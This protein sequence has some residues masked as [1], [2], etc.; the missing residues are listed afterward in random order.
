MGGARWD[1]GM[2]GEESNGR[3]A[4]IFRESVESCAQGARARKECTDHVAQ[5][6]RSQYIPCVYQSVQNAR[7]LKYLVNALGWI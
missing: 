3:P 4:A 2:I 1:R 6:L 5:P 7:R